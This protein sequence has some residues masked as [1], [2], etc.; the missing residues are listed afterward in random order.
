M[1]WI[2]RLRAVARTLLG[3][4]SVFLTL[5]FVES[6]LLFEIAIDSFDEIKYSDI[7]DTGM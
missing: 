6:T 3:V 2:P 4:E 1:E 7:I 5:R